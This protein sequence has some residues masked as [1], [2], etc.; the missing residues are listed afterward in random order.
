MTRPLVTLP[1]PEFA[2]PFEAGSLKYWELVAYLM[3][4]T[5]ATQESSERWLREQ[6]A[7]IVKMRK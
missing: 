2:I 1:D 3:R 5:G 6:K 7:C 4:Y